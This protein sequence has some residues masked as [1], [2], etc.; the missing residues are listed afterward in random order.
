MDKIILVPESRG[1]PW[2]ETLSA[3]LKTKKNGNKGE[4]N[5]KPL[6]LACELSGISA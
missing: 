1:N 4:R 3:I 6:L 5:L 2:S